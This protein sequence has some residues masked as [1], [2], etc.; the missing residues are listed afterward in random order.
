[1]ANG[2]KRRAPAKA[3]IENGELARI[4][5]DS[6]AEAIYAIDMLGN[7]TFC[8]AACLRLL[9]YKDPVELI[10]KNMHRVMHSYSPGWS[11][12]PQRRMPYLPGFSPRRRQPRG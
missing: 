9:G 8:N 2:L 4:L 10:G 5:L 7:C 12:L 11:A 3:W 1:M 6:M